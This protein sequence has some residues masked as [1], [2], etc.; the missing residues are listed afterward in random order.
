MLQSCV[1]IN[2]CSIQSKQ[3]FTLQRHSL[4][5]QHLRSAGST[6]FVSSP[7]WLLLLPRCCCSSRLPLLM[8]GCV[9]LIAQQRAAHV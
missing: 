5:P 7:H 8:Q 6:C 3:T 2:R 4:T 9:E 1:I